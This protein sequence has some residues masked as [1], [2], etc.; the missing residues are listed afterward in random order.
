MSN[1]TEIPLTTRPQNKHK[2]LLD[3]EKIFVQRQD[4]LWRALRERYRY[5][6][7][8]KQ[9]QEY[10][11]RHVNSKM[12]LVIMYADLVGSTQMS[13]TLHLDKLIYKSFHFN[14]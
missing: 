8:I 10:L 5:N 11:L 3:L 12:P 1:W 4:R 13:M 9:S 2:T 7:S 6:T 14:C